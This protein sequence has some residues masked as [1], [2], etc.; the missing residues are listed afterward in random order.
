MYRIIQAQTI[1]DLEYK[2]NEELEREQLTLL[3]QPSYDLHN[4]CYIQAVLGK[5]D[6]GE[7]VKEPAKPSGSGLKNLRAK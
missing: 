3:G 2:V 5:K 4:G 6:D 7:R 1:H